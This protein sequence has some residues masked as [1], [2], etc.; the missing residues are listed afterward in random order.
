MGSKIVLTM[1]KNNI[2]DK[3]LHCYFLEQSEQLIQLFAFSC[4]GWFCCAKLRMA[5]LSFVVWSQLARQRIIFSLDLTRTY[6]LYDGGQ[7]NLTIFRR[8][9]PPSFA[10][11]YKG[12]LNLQSFI[13]TL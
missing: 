12:G 8:F 1:W 10:Y 4:V 9:S 7:C 3:I 13:H 6:I 5:H 11:M 2:D